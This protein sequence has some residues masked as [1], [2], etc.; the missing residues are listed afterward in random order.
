MFSDPLDDLFDL[1]KKSVWFYRVIR[2]NTTL[3]IV[4]PML[5]LALFVFYV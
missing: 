4:T 3:S 2:H 1:A 5:I